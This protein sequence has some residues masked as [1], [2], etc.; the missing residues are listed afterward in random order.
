M[1]AGGGVEVLKGE[2]GIVCPSGLP[3]ER[4]SEVVCSAL[5]S[6]KVRTL[7]A[8]LSS[9][10]TILVFVTT[11]NV[12]HGVPLRC[13]ALGHLKLG[14]RELRGRFQ[15]SKHSLGRAASAKPYL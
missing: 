1:S 12:L 3:T 4:S 13:T 11:V 8:E 5:G 9:A 15:E 7:W 10:R 14:G 2:F 6:Q